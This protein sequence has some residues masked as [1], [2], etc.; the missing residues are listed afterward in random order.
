MNVPRVPPVGFP[1]H[2]HQPVDR[3]VNRDFIGCGGDAHA[4]CPE[5]RFHPRRKVKV[6][7]LHGQGI[8]LKDNHLDITEERGVLHPVSAGRKHFAG[9]IIEE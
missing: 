2:V 4:P 5:P 7:R 6:R 1:K 8:Q 3:L 9:H